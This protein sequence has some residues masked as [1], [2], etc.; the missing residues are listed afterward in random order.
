M[1]K[2]IFRRRVAVLGAAAAALG[3]S[4]VAASTGSA[5]AATRS[6]GD[7]L[8]RARPPHVH[9]SALKS[10]SP[11]LTPAQCLAQTGGAFACHDPASIHAAY[12]IPTTVDGALAGTGQTIVIVD[13]FGSPT[14]EADLAKFDAAFQL[15]APPSLKVIHPQGK[16]TWQ[17]TANQVGWAEESSLDVQWAHAVAPGANIVLD[18][19]VT[20]YGSALNNAVNYAVQ[21]HLGNVIS[22]SYGEPESMVH[23]NSTQ[24]RQ[25]HE[26]FAAAVKAGITPLASSGDSGADNYAGYAN[27]AYP[28]NDPLVTAVGGTDLWAGSGLSPARETTWGDYDPSTCLTGCPDGPFGATGGAPSLATGKQGS[29]VSYNAGV[30]TGVLTYLGFLGGNDNGFYFFGGTSAGSPQWAGIVAMVDQARAKSHRA[31][32]GNLRD[33]LESLSSAG[34]L[35]DVTVGS[36]ETPSFRSGFSAH[37]GKDLPTGYGSPNAAE[38]ITTLR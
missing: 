26:I 18:V 11:R 1:T 5:V 24:Q 37:G 33:Q 29:D 38:V 3:G 31:P 13:A 4:L 28:A 30:Y 35:F 34:D 7:V 2:S 25:S 32:I 17:G 16:P 21:H 10:I 9:A 23:G 20:N 22:M 19:A 27:F 12:N 6:S 15:P 8:Y 36:N 14:L